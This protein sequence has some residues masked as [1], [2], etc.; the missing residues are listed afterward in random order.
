MLLLWILLALLLVAFAIALGAY[1][2]AYQSP[3]KGQNDPY[4][5]P[6]GSRYT[7]ES[8]PMYGMIREMEQLPWEEIQIRSHDGLLLF[9]RYLHVADGAPLQ[10]QMHGYRGQAFRDFCGG[11]K[12]ARELGLNTLVVDQRAH[13]KS[14]GHTISFGINERWDCQAWA[15]YAAERWPGTPITLAGISMGAATVLMASD[16]PLPEEVC[17][18]LADCGYTSPRAIIKKVCWDM[19]RYMRIL[20]PFTSLSAELFGHFDPDAGSAL[21]ALANTRLP[22]LLVH[23][24]ADAFVPCEMSRELAAGCAS[25]VTLETFPGAGHGGSYLSDP[26]RYSRIVRDFLERCGGI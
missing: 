26:E 24:E 15:E 23:G 2:F 13:G 12:I 4:F 16:L 10:I 14:Q 20:Y 3:H 18:I 19:P 1:L 11:N 17:G 25:P 6:D 8:G 7:P 5:A 22:I 21:G 9:G